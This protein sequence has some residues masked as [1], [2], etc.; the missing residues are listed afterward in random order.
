MADFALA[1]GHCHGKDSLMPG[2][3]VNQRGANGQRAFTL[4]ELLVVIAIIA[5]LAAMLLPA[6]SKAK[7]LARRASCA[8]NLRQLRLA[9]A[10][11]ATDNNNAFPPRIRTARW[12]AQL[13]P[14]YAQ[15]D[16]LRCAADLQNSPVTNTNRSPDLAPRSYLLNGFQDVF[17]AQGLPAAKE[18]PPVKESSIQKPVDTILFG[19]KRSDSAAYYLCLTNEMEAALAT[20]EESRHGGTEVAADK[21]G[22]S[23]YGFADGS[24]RSLRYG[25]SLCP[26]NLWGL[27]E[28][29]RTSYAVCRPH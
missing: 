19:E 14:H 18:Y 23:N 8:N 26:I 28:E 16:L 17:D 2:G 5:I 10:V 29:A 13:Q 9:A 7:G 3:R 21:S 27:T 6:L 12:P 24:V 11:Y 1:S 20:I 4:I 22:S 15:I 25:R